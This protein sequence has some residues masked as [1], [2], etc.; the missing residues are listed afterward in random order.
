M[1]CSSDTPDFG[2]PYQVGTLRPVHPILPKITS[3]RDTPGTPPFV[4]F[5]KSMILDTDVILLYQQ[6]RIP[7]SAFIRVCNWNHS[8]S[9][10]FCVDPKIDIL[11]LLQHTGN[12]PPRDASEKRSLRANRRV[13]NAFVLPRPPTL[14]FID[15]LSIA[16]E[17]AE[18]RK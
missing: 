1:G 11:Q 3:G 4:H 16:A 10:A 7:A 14:H 6:P 15:R 2:F 17:D 12:M 5:I 9:R 18:T 8:S 13:R